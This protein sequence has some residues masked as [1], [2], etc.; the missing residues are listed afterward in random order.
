MM[1]QVLVAIDRALVGTM[2]VVWGL[3]V[4]TETVLGAVWLYDVVTRLGA[5]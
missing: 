4:A 2:W 1:V 5:Q 3:Y